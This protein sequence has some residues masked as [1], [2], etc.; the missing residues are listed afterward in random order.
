MRT[1]HS[2]V[3]RVV[4]SVRWLARLTSATFAIGCLTLLLYG[5]G[6]NVSGAPTS[7]DPWMIL[8]LALV[9][10]GA[11]LAWPWEGL[12]GVILTAV[13]LYA[14]LIETTQGVM[15]AGIWLTLALGGAF[16]ACWGYC[17]LPLKRTAPLKPPHATPPTP[18]QQERELVGA[19]RP[20]R[21]RIPV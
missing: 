12:G 21:E 5:L 17:L 13:G 6:Q 4:V 8:F 18:V 20:T 1:P 19:D 3:D 7:V 16:L 14:A 11:V 15:D 9:A 10:I 2:L